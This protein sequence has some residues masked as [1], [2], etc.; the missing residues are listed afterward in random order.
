MLA[1]EMKGFFVPLHETVF[2]LK[3][4]RRE[5]K[6]RVQFEIES[7]KEIWWALKAFCLDKEKNYPS[8]F[9]FMPF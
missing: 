7:F 6:K 3:K 2:S 9:T 4:K 1:F 5:K 8:I